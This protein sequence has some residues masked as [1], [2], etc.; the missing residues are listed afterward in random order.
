MRYSE[1]EQLFE[2]SCTFPI[3]HQTVIEQVGDVKLTTPTGDSIAVGDVLELT[4][5]TTYRSSNEL[6][7]SLLGNLGD[8][9]IG[10]K[11]YDDRAGAQSGTENRRGGPV[12]F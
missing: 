2:Q 8:S 12:S 11:Y 4:D 5:E 6:Y 1:T 3:N 7:L 10:R 9:F